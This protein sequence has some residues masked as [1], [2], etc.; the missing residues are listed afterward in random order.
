M[1]LH[2]PSIHTPAHV[3]HIPGWVFAATVGVLLIG[4][5]LVVRPVS[6]P[7]SGTSTTFA[8][9]QVSAAYQ[10]YR[11]DERADYFAPG[12]VSA[13]YQAYRA[14]ERAPNSAADAA[15][16]YRQYRQGERQPLSP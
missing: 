13:A 12:Q 2:A 7:T 4:I 9:S 16:A 3:P 10:A 11:A 5:L 8:P 6:A 1:A 14:D 15:A